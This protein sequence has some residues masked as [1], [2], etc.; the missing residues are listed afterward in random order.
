MR[1][2]QMFFHRSILATSYLLFPV[3]DPHTAMQMDDFPLFVSTFV[4]V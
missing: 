1:L 2:P 4:P 3:F